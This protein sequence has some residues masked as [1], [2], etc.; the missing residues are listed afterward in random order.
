MNKK[1]LK[2]PLFLNVISCVLTIAFLIA[3]YDLIP[4]MHKVKALFILV[5][6]FYILLVATFALFYKYDHKNR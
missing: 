4:I 2:H 3:F 6:L 1:E 5:P